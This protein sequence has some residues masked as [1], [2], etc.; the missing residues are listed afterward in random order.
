MLLAFRELSVKE[1]LRRWAVETGGLSS[2]SPACTLVYHLTFLEHKNKTKQN[3]MTTTSH[4]RNLGFQQCPCQYINFSSWLLSPQSSLLPG[5]RTYFMLKCFHPTN[6]MSIQPGN[7]AFFN[8]QNLPRAWKYLLLGLWGIRKHM[9]LGIWKTVV[10]SF[11]L[12]VNFG[13]DQTI[14]FRLV[15]LRSLETRRGG[16][17]H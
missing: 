8:T 17:E 12:A 14:S 11:T 4:G 5:R 2:N 7:E 15:P 16:S 10:Q 1:R 3:N 6:R 9:D 13:A